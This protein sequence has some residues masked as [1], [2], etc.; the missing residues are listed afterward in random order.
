MSYCSSRHICLR[1]LKQWIWWLAHKH[2]VVQ[3]GIFRVSCFW[4]RCIYLGCSSEAAPTADQGEVRVTNRERKKWE[5][6][7]KR[8]RGGRLEEWICHQNKIP[9]TRQQVAKGNLSSSAELTHTDTQISAGNNSASSFLC[10]LL[11][12]FLNYCKLNVNPSRHIFI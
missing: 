1:W 12:S 6:E 8:K 7:R 4:G 2:A 3:Q 10:I 11:F 5:E 9:F